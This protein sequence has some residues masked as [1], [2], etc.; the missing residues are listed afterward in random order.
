MKRK[1]EVIKEKGK[2]PLLTHRA[3]A[4]MFG[5]GRTQIAQI[6][7]KKDTIMTIYQSNAAGSRIHKNKI[8]CVSEYQQI[9][10]A[11]YEWYTIACSKNIYPG[12]PELIEKAKLIAEKL[13]KS[14]FK[15]TNGWFGKWKERYNIKQATVCGESGDVQLSTVDSWKE[16]L[17]EIVQG[18]KKEDILNMDETGIFWRALPDKGFGERGKACKGGGRPVREE[19]RVKSE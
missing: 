10:E 8:S 19:R 14:E 6:L 1:L 3:L 15:G 4:E 13:G 16:R 11:L 5:C 17:P 9:N 12:G 7:K 18:Y 2:N